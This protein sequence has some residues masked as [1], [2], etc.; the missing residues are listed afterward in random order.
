[1]TKT[2]NILDHQFF[3]DL[4]ERHKNIAFLLDFNKFLIIINSN[5]WEISD[6]EQINI[7]SINFFN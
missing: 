4:L 2:W 6:E 3:Q 1:M 5:F 7:F